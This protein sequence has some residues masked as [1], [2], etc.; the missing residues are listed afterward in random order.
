MA[1]DQPKPIKVRRDQHAK[2]EIITESPVPSLIG[3]TIGEGG[4]FPSWEAL[5][6]MLSEA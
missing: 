3:K 1:T 6:R 2:L 4:D 5:Y